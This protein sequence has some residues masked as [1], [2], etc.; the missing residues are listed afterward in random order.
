LLA[1]VSRA[2]NRLSP[3]HPHKSYGS[4]ILD[5][6]AHQKIDTLPK[7]KISFQIPPSPGHIFHDVTAQGSTVRYH[8]Q[9]Q[10]LDCKDIGF[11]DFVAG[12]A[13]LADDPSTDISQRSLTPYSASDI[14]ASCEKGLASCSVTLPKF[15]H[16]ID[17]AAR[18]VHSEDPS[19]EFRL[20]TTITPAGSITDPH[21]DGSGSGLLLF[22]LFGTKVLF[23]WPS[24]VRNLHWFEPRHGLRQGSLILDRA[25]QELSGLRLTIL[26]RHEV[27][28]LAP[29]MIH[30]V[31]SPNNSAI[32]GWN[33]VRAN[34]ISL[35]AV[36]R[37]MLWEAE[38]VRRQ[39][40]EGWDHVYNLEDYLNDDL[41][42][43]E[44]LA[45]RQ[46]SSNPALAR[47]IRALIR[48]VRQAI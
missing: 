34:W 38:L 27:V 2:W 18:R 40:V 10:D 3:R 22:Q 29:G 48:L 17:V 30:A 11:C 33:F 41:R 6:L 8:N 4:N 42:L 14:L 32:S 13:S 31:M 37:N 5:L 21:I 20:T 1:H 43:W 39:M 28:E 23:T 45:L 25:I 26:E 35:Q 44:T 19:S 9:F 36:Q 12:W 47:R 24:S 7:S 46:A 16:D 15:F